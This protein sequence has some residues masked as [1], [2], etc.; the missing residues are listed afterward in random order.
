M[1]KPKFVIVEDNAAHL[2]ILSGGLAKTG[3][4]S[5]SIHV[6]GT[7]D[8]DSALEVTNARRV[9]VLFSD[10]HLIGPQAGSDANI[11]YG[12]IASFI[13]ASQPGGGGPW[14]L[15]MWT[16]NLQEA[17]GLE[18]YLKGSLDASLLPLAVVPLSKDEYLP[19]AEK[20]PGAIEKLLEKYP[21]V[22]ALLDWEESVA[23]AAAD[24]IA[25]LAEAARNHEEKANVKNGIGRL[26]GF[27]AQA[28]FGEG[29]AKDEFG[30]VASGLAPL[31]ADRVTNADKGKKSSEPWKSAVVMPTTHRLSAD[32]RARLNAMLHIDARAPSALQ[33]CQ[34]GTFCRLPDTWRR[35]ADFR[36]MFG[37]MDPMKAQYKIAAAAPADLEWG[38]VSFRAPCD[39][40]QKKPGPIPFAL[41]L[42]GAN[43]HWFKGNSGDDKRSGFAD[44]MWYSPQ[45]RRNDI[46]KRLLISASY[47]VYLP[48]K[49]GTRLAPMFR[50]RDQLLV[51]LTAHIHTHGARQAIVSF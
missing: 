37:E 30:A 25:T 42:E 11:H 44:A 39:D 12:V 1:A 4:A 17:A 43:D 45:Y 48:E 28:S 5:L 38:L 36:K 14:L 15:V 23:D 3:K 19:A 26:L 33:P 22:R 40:A 13:Q 10:L 2:A 51:Q 50:L 46:T 31:V 8:P 47:V 6:G 24:T 21:S 16:E 41:A 29:A 32:V 34:I 35:D 9:R 27:I 18:A 20:L 7:F 49:R